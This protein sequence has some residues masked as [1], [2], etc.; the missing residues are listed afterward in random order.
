MLENIKSSFFQ[1]IIFLLLDER[2]KLQLIKYNKNFQNLL[3]IKLINYKIFSGKYIIKEE[4]NKIKEYNYFNNKLIYEGEYLN[5]KRNGKGKEYDIKGFLIFEGEYFNG[6]KWNGKI[7]N[8]LNNNITYQLTNG[9][10]FIKEYFDDNDTYGNLKFEGEYLNG[11]RNGKGKEYA[12]VDILVFE[13]EYL[14]GKKWNGKG[15]FNNRSFEL[16]DGIISIEE[17]D[18]NGLLTLS[19]HYLK[20]EKTGKWILHNEEGKLLYKASYLNDKRNGKFISYYY[21]GELFFEGEYSND[22]K[23]KEK[24]I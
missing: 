17:Y 3:D 22:L 2:R 10:G 21:N 11:E 18:N 5:G 24:I 6:K 14:K 12:P 23:K 9:K 7:F 4:N 8:D 15:Y 20:G 13:G 19:F 16:K 1:K